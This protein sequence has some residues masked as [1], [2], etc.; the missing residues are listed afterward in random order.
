MKGFYAHKNIIIEGNVFVNPACAA[1]F[2]RNVDG[3][4]A[5]NNTVLRPDG[6]IINAKSQQPE[7]GKVLFDIGNSIIT[8][9]N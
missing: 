4:S 7:N 1:M 9:E 6:G 2:I 5:L 8:P 3:L